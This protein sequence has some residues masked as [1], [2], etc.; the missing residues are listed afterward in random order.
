MWLL[1][2]LLDAGA[3]VEGSAV[4]S[5]E[6]NYTETPLQL[7]SAAG[8]LRAA[9]ARSVSCYPRITTTNSH[10]GQKKYQRGRT[11]SWLL[12]KISIFFIS[13]TL[14]G[15]LTGLAASYSCRHVWQELDGH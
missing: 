1:Q 9:S 10:V 2:L 7:A 14:V 6:D 3:H 4:N 5:G 15:T 8:K 11:V 12:E 13:K